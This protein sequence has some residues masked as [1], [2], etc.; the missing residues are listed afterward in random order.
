MNDGEEILCSSC[1]SQMDTNDISPNKTVT[2]MI[3]KMKTRCPT[4]I[5]NQCK[6]GDNDG[7]AE[8]NIIITQVKDNECDW[9]GTIKE[10]KD[11]KHQCPYHM[12]LC[13]QCNEY[14]GK[15]MD[16]E[17]H[18]NECPWSNISCPNQCGMYYVSHRIM[19][20]HYCLYLG[21]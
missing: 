20:K 21:V 12:I 13:Q 3:N 9:N 18:L 19:Y 5:Y 15:R 8:G 6:P 17:S 14:E 7:S 11:H 2:N 4:L 10:W 1:S 16:M